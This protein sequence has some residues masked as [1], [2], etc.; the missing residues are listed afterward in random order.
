MGSDFADLDQKLFGWV[1]KLVRSVTSR[2]AS[3]SPHAVELEPLAPRLSFLASAIAEHRVRV[4]PTDGDGGISGTAI[5]MPRRLDVL[6]DV[7][8][9]VGLYVLRTA[10][11]ATAVRCGIARPEGLSDDESRVLALLLLPSLRTRLAHELEGSSG[12]FDVLAPRL[13]AR[14]PTLAEPS[15]R[16]TAVECCVAWALGGSPL[17]GC[18]TDM[19]A[20]LA[21]LPLAEPRVALEEALPLVRHLASLRDRKGARIVPGVPL[22]GQLLPWRTEGSRDTEGGP[23]DASALPKGTERKA[24]T[25]DYVKRIELPEE[26]EGENPLEHS[27][28]KV[29]TAETYQGG[30]KALDGEDEL[31]AHGDA[32]DELDVK[33]VIRTREV[34]RSVYRMDGGLDGEAPELEDVPLEG[35]HVRHYDEWDGEKYRKEFCRLV[36][37]L[38]AAPNERSALARLREL[39]G[40]KQRIRKVFESIEDAR[41]ARNRQPSGGEVDVDAVVERYAFVHAGHEGPDRLYVDRR[42]VEQDLS[43]LILLDLSSSSD[44]WLEGR[45]VLDMAR[46]AV[47]TVS[48]V[49]DE[50][51]APFAIGGFHSHTHR[52]CR[53]VV[54]KGFDERWKAVRGR[55]FVEEPRG[56]TRIGPALRHATAILEGT[57]AK[58]KALLLVT[59]G[60][61]TDY[62]RYEGRYGLT[63][64]KKACDEAIE[65]GVL[66]FALAIA[67]RA[68]PH[69]AE[70][71]GAGGFEILP[72][73]AA[74]ADRLARA[75][76]RWRLS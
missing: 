13:L 25:Q 50:L 5:R 20:K 64:V 75:E 45:R 16:A 49:L 40:Q 69:L 70:M 1:W 60:R 34:A 58:R 26:R 9:N 63:D 53:Y 68:R 31:S 66:P 37:E 10:L 36:V 18:D 17:S 6:D 73:P 42:K 46:E 2:P 8:G 22:A 55:L 72:H 54:L 39:E 14:R 33:E 32:L 38:P 29:H 21:D 15:A 65:R 76:A 11:E 71:F 59:D 61:P 51:G 52:D 7:E 62:D 41:R 57:H 24:R 44:A 23:S 30:R 47:A 74:L 67:D 43:T 27:F 35:A 48:E 4:E 3:L 12:L 56:Y 19:A 28:E